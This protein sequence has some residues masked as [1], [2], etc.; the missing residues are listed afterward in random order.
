MSR[1]DHAHADRPRRS[2]SAGRYRSRYRT[3]GPRAAGRFLGIF[4]I[5][6][7][8]H[9]STL[10]LVAGVDLIEKDCA[11]CAWRRMAQAVPGACF[12]GPGQS[13]TVTVLG[14]LAYGFAAE[15]T[16]L[17]RP[18]R[19]ETVSREI[20]DTLVSWLP[21]PLTL[22]AFWFFTKTSTHYSRVAA[23]VWFVLAP[24]TLCALRATVR[25]GLRI[26][27]AQ[28]H[29]TRRVAILGCTKDAERLAGALDELPWLGLDLQGVYDDRV[30]GASP[31]R[32]VAHPA[33]SWHWPRAHE[34]ASIAPDRRIRLH[35]GT[36]ST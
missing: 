36:P 35:G 28:G 25:I 31:A 17:Y 20:K 13:R 10:C 18:Y 21:V 32:R 9:A 16:G 30:R 2:R 4:R 27:R 11:H 14:L 29:N 12:S 7:Q 6:R 8:A 3:R 26:L 33:S 19:M 22:L 15:V 23:S 34:P 24:I 1:T 5:S